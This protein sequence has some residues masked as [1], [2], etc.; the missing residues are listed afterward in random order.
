MPVLVEHVPT[1]VGFVDPI[2][3]VS[4]ADINA[5]EAHH[6]DSQTDTMN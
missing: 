6:K 3:Q 5:A 2:P 1:L 4:N